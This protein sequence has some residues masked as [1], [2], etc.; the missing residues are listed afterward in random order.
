MALPNGSMERLVEHFSTK[1]ADL[2]FCR[3]IRGAVTE[4]ETQAILREIEKETVDM[5]R[6]LDE[7]RLY[8]ESRSKGLEAFE[9]PYLC[10]SKVSCM[11]IFVFLSL[12]V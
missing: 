8:V 6:R 11:F 12:Y 5:E 4:D 9:V 1:V 10:L 7:L 3:S 2:R